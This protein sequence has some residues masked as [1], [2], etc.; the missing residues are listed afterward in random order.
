MSESLNLKLV[1]CLA[2]ILL[3]E[4]SKAQAP[5]AYLGGILPLVEGSASYTE[6]VAVDSTSKDVLYRKLREWVGDSYRSAKDVIQS[7]DAL[8]ATIV[9]KGI[10]ETLYK[11]SLSRPVD[12]QVEYR[13]TLEAKDSRYRYTIDRIRIQHLAYHLPE[14]SPP[15]HIDEPVETWKRDKPKIHEQVYLAADDS[16]K[17]L[18][19]SLKSAMTAPVKD[20]W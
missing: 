18:I 4:C 12:V 15:D 20:D 10:I 3:W 6:V 19:S 14:G 7:E 17:A 2:G 9:G 5:D 11:Q 1:S 16:F 13:I 8:G